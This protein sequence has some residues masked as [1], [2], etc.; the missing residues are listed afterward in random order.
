ML[1]SDLNRWRAAAEKLLNNLVNGAASRTSV[2]IN[3]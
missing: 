2:E 1:W 3:K